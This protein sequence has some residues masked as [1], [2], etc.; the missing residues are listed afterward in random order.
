MT[1]YFFAD[2]DSVS[3]WSSAL[4]GSNRQILWQDTIGYP[5][6]LA[7]DTIQQKIYWADDG[8]HRIERIDLN[9][10]NRELFYQ[11]N[12]DELPFG[13]YIDQIEA[14]LYW[15]DYGINTIFRSTIDDPSVEVVIDHGLN[16]PIAITVVFPLIEGRSSD[17]ID[18]K[19]KPVISVYP[20]P[21]DDIVTFSSLSKNLMLNQ[22]R[23]FDNLGKQV[24]LENTNQ[25]VVELNTA[26]LS[27]GHYSYVVL[28]DNQ[29]VSG[30]FSI[31]H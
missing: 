10:S 9:G 2:L 6:R 8:L 31:I 23:I 7:I 15:T 29:L 5:V 3:I 11:G 12:S 22:V 20:N 14:K 18:N 26:R 25:H 13:L 21:A 4:D 24:I 17:V 27:E 1:F 28:I 30:H 16:D 19:Y